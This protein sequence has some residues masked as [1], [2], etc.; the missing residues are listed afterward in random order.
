MVLL[1]K[2]PLTYLST[3][4]RA[5]VGIT[6]SPSVGLDQM[7]RWANMCLLYMGPTDATQWYKEEENE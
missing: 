4:C 7:S 1:T 6:V 3:V 2:S 5:E